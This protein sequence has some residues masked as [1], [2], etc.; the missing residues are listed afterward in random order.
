M[1]QT[2]QTMS[3]IARCCCLPNREQ[4]SRRMARSKI[5]KPQTDY[6]QKNDYTIKIH[7]ATWQNIRREMR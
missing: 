6:Y 3:V 7:E 5:S 4:E 2:L 1:A